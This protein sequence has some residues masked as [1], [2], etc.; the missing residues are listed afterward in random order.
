[1]FGLLGGNGAGKSTTFKML[2]GEVTPSFGE[3]YF[4]GRNIK[5]NVSEMQRSIGYCPQT[6][7]LID[8]L[9]VREQLELFYDI[10]CYPRA[11][12][13]QAIEGIMEALS[14]EH[15]EDKLSG[16]LSGGNKRKLSLAIA[17]LGNPD[18]VL[19]DEPSTGMDPVA[20]RHMWR[21]IANITQTRECAL[22]LTTHSM[23]EA[24]ALS[25]KIAI[26]MKGKFKCFGPTQHIK[27]KY[28]KGYEI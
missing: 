2:V 13:E 27:S 8:H 6:D 26:M 25:T 21:V 22:I 18:I 11:E 7:P 10:K 24:E 12:K 3:I 9:T 4:E 1:M 17:I 5:D 15:F 28:G 23:D 20:K 19:L 16:Q 14:L